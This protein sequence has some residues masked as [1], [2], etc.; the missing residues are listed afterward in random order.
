MRIELYATKTDEREF[1]IDSMQMKCIVIADGSKIF[2]NYF[3]SASS[4]PFPF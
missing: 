3:I 1:Q 4:L 2:V